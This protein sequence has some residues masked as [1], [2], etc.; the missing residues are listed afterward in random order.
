MSKEEITDRLRF[1]NSQRI[2][3]NSF[4]V[5]KQLK[6][7]HISAKDVYEKVVYDAVRR[8]T[9]KKKTSSST[10]AIAR[11]K[12]VLSK[13]EMQMLNVLIPKDKRKE[14]AKKQ[15]EGPN[16]EISKKRLGESTYEDW[17]EVKRHDLAEKIPVE[18]EVNVKNMDIRLLIKQIDKAIEFTELEAESIESEVNFLREVKSIVDTFNEQ[19]K[20]L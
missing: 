13:S 8:D 7:P 19:M 10:P 12:T 2:S 6:V 20:D 4:V 1:Q 3:C 11:S 17:Y 14:N 18:E 9:G 16:D 5:H 15:N